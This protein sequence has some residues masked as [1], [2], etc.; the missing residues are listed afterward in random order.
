MATAKKILHNCAVETAA[1]ATCR[2]LRDYRTDLTYDYRPPM[3]PYSC[4]LRVPENSPAWAYDRAKLWSQAESAEG[5]PKYSNA[6]R[7]AAV[8]REVELPAGLEP[9]QCRD[10]GVS[11]ARQ[12]VQ[13]SGCVVDAMVRAPFASA[14]T[15]VLMC[16]TRAMTPD[17]F[18]AKVQIADAWLD[19][20]L[21]TGIAEAIAM[22][23][24]ARSDLDGIFSFPDWTADM[25][26]FFDG[27]FGEACA[28]EPAAT[29]AGRSAQVPLADQL[30][31]LDEVLAPLGIAAPV[32][33]AG[34]VEVTSGHWRA[35]LAEDAAVESWLGALWR[36]ARDLGSRPVSL[37]RV[38]HGAVD[39][40]A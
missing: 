35:S 36:R 21:A 22:A 19:E 20:R 14:R 6:K 2:E 34:P 37:S 13:H 15:L 18:G 16:S 12:I 33:P 32:S 28:V 9:Y 25:E 29:P 3:P 17:G 7:Y 30:K 24:S 11:I 27:T 1:R 38:V 39:R 40:P 5:L 31:A 23:A 26:A 8:L 4:D 10:L